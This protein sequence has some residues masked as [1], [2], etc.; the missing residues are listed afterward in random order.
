MPYDKTYSG[1]NGGSV[2]VAGNWNPSGVPTNANSW[3]IPTAKSA[4]VPAGTNFPVGAGITSLI[5]GS[6]TIQEGG[7]L[8]VAATG[9]LNISGANKFTLVNGG[10]SI[11]NGGAINLLTGATLDLYA[12]SLVNMGTGATISIDAASVFDCYGSLIFNETTAMVSVYGNL[13]SGGWLGTNIGGIAGTGFTPQVTVFSGGTMTLEGMTVDFTIDVQAGGNLEIDGYLYDSSLT[14]EGTATLAP[15][16][17]Y[18]FYQCV[19]SAAGALIASQGSMIFGTSHG[20]PPT[21]LTNGGTLTLLGG[22]CLVIDSSAA[23]FTPGSGFTY[24]ASSV[25]LIDTTFTNP[26]LATL[27][28]AAA[29]AQ[30]ATDQATVAARRPIGLYRP[31]LRPTL[32]P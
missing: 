2:A 26:P 17:M 18:R 5:A 16:G 19:I 3:T 27:E 13:D 22:A 8:S 9:V 29:A 30:L 1:S 15:G 32:L 6:L 14:L 21:Y 12:G 31:R 28:A 23:T 11:E 20:G 7:I 25:V 4:V 24:A 10:G